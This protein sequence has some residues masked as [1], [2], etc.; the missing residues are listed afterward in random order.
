MANILIVDSYD[1]VN[2]LYC[3]VLGEYGHHV[4]SAR[5][6]RDALQVALDEEVFIRLKQL[7]PQIQGIL[8][9]SSIFSDPLNRVRWDGLIAK[10]SDYTV[11]RT[12]VD[13]LAGVDHGGESEGR[14][15]G[16]SG[17]LFPD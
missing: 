8:S 15:S 16:I 7:Q 12:E 9:V 14:Q 17:F 3:E 11:L 10:S 13:K 5:S 4:F 2:L 6:G 1:P